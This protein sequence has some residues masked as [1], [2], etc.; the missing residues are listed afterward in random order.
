[1]N[2]RDFPN[3]KVEFSSSQLILLLNYIEVQVQRELEFTK[4]ET[5]IRGQRKISIA[6]LKTCFYL[7]LGSAHS[8]KFT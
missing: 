5:K 8:T 1:M 6:L 2:D 7:T 4:R 3:K